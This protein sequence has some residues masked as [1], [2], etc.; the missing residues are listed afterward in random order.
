MKLDPH[1]DH[2][3]CMLNA[4]F[5]QFIA[6]RAD[7]IKKTLNEASEHCHH[8]V[9]FLLRR[10]TLGKPP[11]FT[12]IGLGRWCPIILGD[13]ILQAIN[14]V[15]QPIYFIK[16]RSAIIRHQFACQPA[17]PLAAK[18]CLP[19]FAIHPEPAILGVLDDETPAFC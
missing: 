13:A 15:L 2:E 11:P 19:G 4:R 8:F 10:E 17:V 1:P 12:T 9:D 16:K 5:G 14:T 7:N 3:M 18:R 6:K